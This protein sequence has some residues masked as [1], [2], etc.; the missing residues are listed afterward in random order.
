MQCIYKKFK[1]PK[2]EF[3]KF[4]CE[5][6][7]GYNYGTC[8]KKIHKDLH[9]VPSDKFPYL[10]QATV[11]GSRARKTVESSLPTKDNYVN[12]MDS[13]KARCDRESSISRNMYPGFIKNNFEEFV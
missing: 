2:L 7:K 8:L 11:K 12:V 9:I 3:Y 6:K 13:L 10:I 1:L 4:V 5:I